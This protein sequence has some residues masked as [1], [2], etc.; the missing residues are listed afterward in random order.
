MAPATLNPT[1]RLLLGMIQL[2]KRS[3][4]EIK[5]LADIS[6]RFFWNVSYGQIYPELKRL[7]EA[8]LITG[9]DEAQGGRARRVYSLTSAGEQALSGW[10]RDPAALTYEVR[11]EGM[12]K[13]FF[14]DSLDP[15]ERERLLRTMRARHQE[16]VDRLAEIEPD[17]ADK[18][19]GP[20]LT[21]RLGLGFHRAMVE[22]CD[23]LAAEPARR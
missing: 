6:A 19:S 21:L 8:G 17:A 23:E 11:D 12:L 14:S 18:G 16:V 7:E 4:Y 1:S 2:G 22:L 20:Y 3:G 5:Q 13:L 9:E 10:L 15:A